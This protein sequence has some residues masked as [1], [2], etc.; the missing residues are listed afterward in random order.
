MQPALQTRSGPLRQPLQL[1]GANRRRVT[2]PVFH[3]AGTFVGVK[4]SC[5]DTERR[6]V[7]IHQSRPS[8]HLG[9]QYVNTGISGDQNRGF[10]IVI[11]LVIFVPDQPELF[12]YV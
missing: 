12:R 9:S 2:L 1:R 7:N 11:S 8:F 6:F 10:F 5:A 3:S 4:N